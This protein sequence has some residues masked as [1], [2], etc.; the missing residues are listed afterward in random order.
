[1]RNSANQSFDFCSVFRRYFIN[2]ENETAILL[3]KK[4]ETFMDDISYILMIKACMNTNNFEFGN[5]I[6]NKNIDYKN[7]KYNINLMNELIDFYG[8]YGDIKT[9]VSVFDSILNKDII[10]YGSMM[11]AYCI[12]DLNEETI[13]LFKQILNNHSV[14]LYPNKITYAIALKACTNVTSLHFGKGIHNELK[15][16]YN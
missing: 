6:I 11:N 14:S 10:S 1:M 4:Y 7:S 15:K 3:Y 8:H 16:E 5:D 13:K 2:N 9:A 12:N